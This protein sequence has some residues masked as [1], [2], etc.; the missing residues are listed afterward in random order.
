MSDL[1]LKRKVKK[2]KH[3]PSSCHGWI[4]T[5]WMI[6]ADKNARETFRNIL[7]RWIFWL[8][9]TETKHA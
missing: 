9:P 5:K 6:A 4:L 8:K 1:L 2:I 7:L 3:F